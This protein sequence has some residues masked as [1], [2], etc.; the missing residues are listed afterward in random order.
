[1]TRKVEDQARELGAWLRQK[2]RN[3]P[4][5]REVVQLDA[6]TH[7]LAEV[8]GMNQ[9][10]I[11]DAVLARILD[12][13]SNTALSSCCGP[14]RA[15]HAQTERVR[16]APRTRRRRMQGDDSRIAW[17]LVVTDGTGVAVAELP[18]SV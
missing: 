6:R 8:Q 9:R 5:R 17:W 7:A 1:M 15:H 14:G 18:S 4:G 12:D 16:E 3:R 2:D 11:A 10:K 13:V